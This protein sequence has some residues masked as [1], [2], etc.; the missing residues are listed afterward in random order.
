MSHIRACGVSLW[1]ITD[2]AESDRALYEFGKDEG[3]HVRSLAFYRT[4]TAGGRIDW[5]CAALG[6]DCTLRIWSVPALVRQ[7]CGSSF[8]E[9]AAPST[10]K[11]DEMSKQT[12]ELAFALAEEIEE[13]RAVMPNVIIESVRSHG[14]LAVSD[15]LT[16][17]LS[18]QIGI[19]SASCWLVLEPRITLVAFEWRLSFRYDTRTKPRLR[20]T[21][22]L[23]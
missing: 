22:S 12:K 17:V 3:C 11:E 6:T 14:F 23:R 1:R 4:T 18:R 8:V 21:F 19:P 20:F 5:R 15:L 10:I 13:A 2:S 7:G 16:C 9:D